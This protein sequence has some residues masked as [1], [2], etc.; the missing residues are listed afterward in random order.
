MYGFKILAAVDGFARYP[1]AWEL[2]TSLKGTGEIELLPRKC[3][4]SP[5]SRS[6]PLETSDHSRIFFRAVRET[7]FVPKHIVIDGANAWRGASE[8]M[9]LFLG[10]EGG[11]DVVEVDGEK[12]PVRIVQRTSSVHNLVVSWN[13]TQTTCA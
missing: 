5:R 11:T 7:G 13:V 1:I 8:A 9:E 3:H 12:I 2:G 6:T 10:S 4:N